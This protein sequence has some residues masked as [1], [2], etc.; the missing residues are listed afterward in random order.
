M[1]RCNEKQTNEQQQQKHTNK[2]KGL[3]AARGEMTFFCYYL[4]AFIKFSRRACAT[5]QEIPM[6]EKT[7]PRATA[8]VR[9]TVEVL[10]DG[11]G[12]KQS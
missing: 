12:Y 4:P 9:T 5:T 6:K 8:H 3:H 10:P 7:Y 1:K 2:K 11:S